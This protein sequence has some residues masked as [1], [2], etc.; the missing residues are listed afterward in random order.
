MK[1]FLQTA[2]GYKMKSNNHFCSFAENGVHRF[3]FRKKSINSSFLTR[4][5]EGFCRGKVKHYLR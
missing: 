1:S 4:H 5:P 2:P 3:H